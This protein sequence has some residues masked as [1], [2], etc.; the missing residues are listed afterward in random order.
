MKNFRAALLFFLLAVCAMLTA[1]QA[2][3]P[4]VLPSALESSFASP[5]SSEP[6]ASFAEPVISQPEPV[7]SEPEPVISQPEPVSPEPDAP[8]VIDG[9]AIA[10]WDYQGMLGKGMDVDWSKTAKGRTFYNER[11]AADFAAAGVS[12]VR[13]RVTDAADEALLSGLDQQIADCLEN[14]II[15]IIA[16]QA[17][18]FKN[19]PSD[20]NIRKVVKWWRTVAER[21]QDLS[22]L[23]AFDL[24]I[25]ASDAVNKQPEL[26][27]DLYEQVVSAIRESNPTRILILS[28]RLRSDAAYLHELKIPSQH[29]GY[30]MAEWHF[31]ASGPSK[32]NDR[33]LWTTGTEEERALV[34]EKINLALA[35]QRDTGIPTWVG[36]WMAG[37]YNDGNDYPVEE[38]VA[39]ARYMTD[40][41]TG[42]GIPFA[43]NSDSHFYDRETN[44]WI[45]DM[46][47]VFRCIFGE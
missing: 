42:A 25:E 32:S 3:T 5:V 11:A 15:P 24:L 37:N 39:F 36:A 13:L 43:V 47:P 12:H 9:L 29:N 16:Y 41:L 10:P 21:Y 23:L 2:T 14:G 19:D 27:N 44:R 35:W 30:L 33:K 18:D 34:T 40:S 31:Y 1:C 6:T 46:Q 7:S 8:T 4:T 45:K 38:Q 26:L 20:K 17:D 22:P 28:P